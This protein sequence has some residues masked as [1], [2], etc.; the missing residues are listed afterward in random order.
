MRILVNIVL[1]IFLVQFV[2]CD[3]EENVPEKPQI[4]GVKTLKIGK[5]ENT[6]TRRYPTQL[7]STDISA[8][9]FEI[10][11]RLEEKHLEVGQQVRAGQRLFT[12]DPTSLHLAVGKAEA[13]LQQ[14]LATASDAQSD[15]QRQLSLYQQKIVSRS[16][17]ERATTA[18]K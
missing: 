16:K 10:G 13:A 6:I 15:L 1:V 14:A 2:A 3:R 9:S 5:I 11:G 12:L 17:V 18:K 4:R 7:Q 8:L